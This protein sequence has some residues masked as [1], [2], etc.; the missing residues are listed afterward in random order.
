MARLAMARASVLT[1]ASMSEGA[2]Y[3]SGRWLQPFLQGMKIMLVGQ[4]LAMKSVSWYARLTMDMR[5]RLR[6]SA[7]TSTAVITLP[8]DGAGGSWLIISTETL[9]FLFFAIS[10]ARSMM[11]ATTRSR[12]GPSMSRTSISQWASRGTLLMAPGP[13]RRTPIVATVSLTPVM[14]AASSTASASSAAASPASFLYGMSCPPAW[15]PSPRKSTMKAAGAAT[16]VTTPML[17]P[18]ISRRGPC[19]MCSS[20]KE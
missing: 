10:W 16:A 6:A 20:T 17:T 13:R 4:S 7:A 14:R 8:P 9:T 18:F 19:S 12:R 1:P 5:E 3:S 15:P 11:R 2:A